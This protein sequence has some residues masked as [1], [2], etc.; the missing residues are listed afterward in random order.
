MSF[1]N[2]LL[3]LLGILFIGMFTACDKFEGSQTVPSYLRVDTIFLVNNPQIE[4]GKITHN[5]TDVWVYVD[6]QTIGSFELRGINTEVPLAVPILTEGTHKLSLYAGIKFNGMSGT[7]GPYPFVKPKI[8]ENFNFVKDSIVKINPSVSYYETVTFT[9][10]EEFEDGSLSIIETSSSDTLMTTFEH[11]PI[12][13]ALG[14][15]SG[16]A[17]IDDEN[18]TFEISSYDPELSGYSL[19]GGGQ[20]VLMEVEYNINVHMSV[21]LFIRQVGVGIT[22]HAVL[23]LTPTNG[24][25]KKVYVNFTPAIDAYP[26]GD[27]Y[28]VF[29]R[30]EYESGV[31]TGIIMLDNL[32]LLHRG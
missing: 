29:F 9:W 12:N 19:P 28:N 11:E 31:E 16:I 2:K 26:N 18:S 27:Y 15:R 7:R 21:G 32:K 8:F 24:K 4:E 1:D 13:P 6:D 17:Y 5:F 23:I 30:A 3:A 10:T 25:W 14:N 20:P 22:Q